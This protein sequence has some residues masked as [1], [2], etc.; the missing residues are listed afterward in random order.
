MDKNRLLP[1]EIRLTTNRK[2]L[3][4]SYGARVYSLT[5]EYL[6]VHVPSTE[7]SGQ[8]AAQEV[9]L[10]DKRDV[11]MKEVHPTG[12][13]ALE[14]NFSDGYNSGLYDWEYL[15]RLSVLQEI[16]WK[17]YLDRLK[18]AGISRGE[19]NKTVKVSITSITKSE[20]S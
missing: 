1:E 7:I 5:A 14:I 18:A 15:Y 8:G 2:V 20:K 9:L 12:N 19:A 16:L 4:L 17:D 10:A 3:R 6:R 11:V 13:Y